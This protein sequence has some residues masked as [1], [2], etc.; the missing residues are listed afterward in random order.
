MAPLR[1]ISN[2]T[3]RYDYEYEIKPKR[4][5]YVIT[6]GS[7]T[8]RKYFE[9]IDDNRE[10]SKINSLLDIVFLRKEEDL[11]GHSSPKN[12][13]TLIEQKR[14]ELIQKEGYNSELDRFVIVF[15]RDSFSSE[16][17]YTGF[18]RQA[19]DNNLLAI[20]SPCFEIWLFLHQENSVEKIILNSYDNILR[21]CRVSN[22]HSY[23]SELTSSILGMNP[24]KRIPKEILLDNI[25]VAIDQEK[26][27]N[28][29]VYKMFNNIGSNIGS[30]ILEM[31][32]E[33]LSRY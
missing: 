14:R 32:D 26:L 20:T 23:V 15:D 10:R 25:D 28:N 27:L 7:R 16:E 30:L 18:V 19:K 13:L 17:D 31:R 2:W 9:I 4:R 21:N 1:E 29:D 3:N 8:E 6:E 5:Y 33:D 24:K 11:K 22:N 12:L